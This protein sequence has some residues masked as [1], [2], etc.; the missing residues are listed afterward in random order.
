MGNAVVD[1]A[2]LIIQK[3]LI[4]P[5]D[6]IQ[7]A[8]YK[9]GSRREGWRARAKCG[10]DFTDWRQDQAKRLCWGC[11]VR[12]QCLADALDNGLNA[13]QDHVRGGYPS[14]DRYYLARIWG[15]LR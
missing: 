13:E 12:L 11:P 3:V 5:D 14:W 7:A 10:P 8:K 2:E 4:R 1:T 15:T 6:L 9:G